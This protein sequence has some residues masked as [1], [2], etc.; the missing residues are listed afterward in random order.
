MACRRKIVQ[1]GRTPRVARTM[2]MHHPEYVWL[3]AIE[4]VLFGAGGR[5]E[6]RANRE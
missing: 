6:M 3:H 1:L 4:I 5:F 2:K